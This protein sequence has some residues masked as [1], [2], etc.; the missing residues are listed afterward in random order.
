MTIEGVSLM[1]NHRSRIWEIIA[2]DSPDNL[3]EILRKENK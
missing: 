1:K 2:Q 3:N